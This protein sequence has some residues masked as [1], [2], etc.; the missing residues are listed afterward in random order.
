MSEVSCFRCRC[1]WPLRGFSLAGKFNQNPGQNQARKYCSSCWFHYA[2]KA[3]LR[4][5]SGIGKIQCEE[6]NDYPDGQRVRA[7][8][9]QKP[10]QRKHYEH[11]HHEEIGGQSSIG[12]R[13]FT[14]YRG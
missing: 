14:Q 1:A 12:N 3:W 8:S 7:D 11:K 2:E 5:E 4:N 10:N 13:R 6:V 9:K